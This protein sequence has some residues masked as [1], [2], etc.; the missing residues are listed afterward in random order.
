MNE[1]GSV[2]PQRLRRVGEAILPRVSAR[3]SLALVAVGLALGGCTFARRA[4]VN[5]VDTQLRARGDHLTRDEDADSLRMGD[6]Q[7]ESLEVEQT[8]VDPDGVLAKQDIARPIIQHH[9]HMQMRSPS[10]GR[11][12]VECTQ[13]RRQST[14]ADYAAV[15]EEN[16]DDVA[17]T[18][19]LRAGSDAR[20]RFVT[21]ADVA[22]NFRGRLT[23]A[24]ADASPLD[25][26]ILVYIQRFGWLRRHLPDPVAQVRQK[27]TAVAAMLLG[28]PEEAWVSAELDP[29]LAEPSVATMLALRHLPLGLDD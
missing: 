25:I 17:V 9:L 8:K 14:S 15:V 4:S 11:W 18:C 19:D 12:Q 28:R 6:Y 2:G 22:H 5:A 7:V 27:D 20:W 23:S 13:Q 29:A 1:S 24:Q 16:R 10:G 21:E 26:E 3:G